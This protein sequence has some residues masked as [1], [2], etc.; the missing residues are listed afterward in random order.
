MLAAKLRCL[1]MIFIAGLSALGCGAPACAQEDHVVMTLPANV[2][3]FLGIYAARDLNFWKREGLDVKT[4]L[5]PGVGSFN[6]VVAGSAEFSVSSGAALTRAAAHGQRMLAIANMIDKPVWSIVI[7]KKMAE[8]A[9][10]DPKAPLAERARLMKGKRM[11]IDAINS[12]IH[13]YLRVI[14]KAG[15]IDPDSLTIAPMQPPD[16]LAAFARGALDGFVAGPPWPQRVEANG[17]GVVIASPVTN[18][19]PWIV[20]NG[21]GVVVTR[22]QYCVEHRSICMKL[23]HGLAEGARF[24]H[25]HPKQAIALMQKHFDKIPPQ[26]VALAFK[27]VQAG[28]PVPPAMSAAV[29][30]NSE[31]LNIE[32]G[33]LKPA[34]A[35]KSYNGLY[36][37]EFV[38]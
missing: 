16:T 6:A 8:A 3:Q 11:G 1:G 34:D 24:I 14:A 38:R 4:I 29:L 25:D 5:V 31:R 13:A 17:T 10:F 37:T 12:V 20:P 18:D 27:V 9:H 33:L 32:A 26:I 36:T 23:G 15:G 28:T 35:L 7:N 19:P 2:M 21:S 30:R 22:P